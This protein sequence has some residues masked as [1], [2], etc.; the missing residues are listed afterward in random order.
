MIIFLV[1]RKSNV[2]KIFHIYNHMSLIFSL[3]TIHYRGYHI[4]PVLL[5]LA[6]LSFYTS[7]YSQK[8]AFY[9]QSN[10][11]YPKI[12][13]FTSGILQNKSDTT[14]SVNCIFHLTI[15]ENIIYRKEELGL[16]I[17]PG[18][19]HFSLDST[20][21]SHDFLTANGY[22]LPG[23][24]HVHLYF[25]TNGQDSIKIHRTIVVPPYEVVYEAISPQKYAVRCFP[26]DPSVQLYFITA[27]Q[28][29]LKH[30]LKPLSA[31]FITNGLIHK[32]QFVKDSNKMD[33][34]L[35]RSELFYRG[36]IIG[37]TTYQTWEKLTNTQIDTSEIV[38]QQKRPIVGLNSFVLLESGYT[39]ITYPNQL[40]QPFYTR[41]TL[42]PTVSV[43]GIPLTFNSMISTENNSFY[44]VNAFQFGIDGNQF[45]S[46]FS[47]NQ[48]TQQVATEQRLANHKQELQEVSAAIH[49][50]QLLSKPHL[51]V[52][53]DTNIVTDTLHQLKNNQIRQRRLLNQR[54]ASNKLIQLEQREAFLKDALQKDSLLLHRQKYQGIT[55][56]TLNRLIKNERYKGLIKGLLALNEFKVGLVTPHYS[57]H[58]LS[59]TPIYGL[60]TDM[61]FK[62]WC[63]KA[64][65]GN[66]LAFQPT[67]GLRSRQVP[68]FN[69]RTIA[70]QLGI[71]DRR[72]SLKVF[73][74]YYY[75]KNA[76]NNFAPNTSENHVISSGI[77]GYMI[78]DLTLKLEVAKSFFIADLNNKEYYTNNT[79][80]KTFDHNNGYMAYLFESNYKLNHNT[81]FEAKIRRL[82]AGYHSLGMPFLRTDLIEY[83]IKWQQYYWH[84]QIETALHYLLNRDNLLGN[85]SNTTVLKGYGAILRTHFRNKPNFLISYQPFNSQL[86][87]QERSVEWNAPAELITQQFY[88]LHVTLFYNKKI[89]AGQLQTN[90][91][92]QRS[93][94]QNSIGVV[95]KQETYQGNMSLSLVGGKQISYQLAT[96]ITELTS[97]SGQLHD[98][99][100]TLPLLKQKINFTLG[101]TGQYMQDQK[102]RQGA[103]AFTSYS[104]KKLVLSCRLSV[105]YLQ[106]DWGTLTN[107]NPEQQ[108]YFS[109]AHR[110]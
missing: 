108:V 37:K 76:P 101:L 109:I 45:K 90:T 107:G 99:A 75:F 82:D 95:Y 20:F 3:S 103:Y 65:I 64:T 42:N 102:T 24:Y 96:Y 67:F 17:K 71:I 104:L 62:R 52:P 87:I 19:T 36:V 110:F 80:N 7:I 85:K 81:F 32:Q 41:L 1:I 29:K 68:K 84:K 30:H 8:I 49:K 6:F 9:P 100:F 58:I 34:L 51:E 83:G 59:Q 86:I 35:F 54:E 15:N 28:G 60:H 77:E 12:T 50:Q 27:K 33:K 46:Y 43:L 39:N 55:N 61:E 21:S 72:N 53:L 2:G 48:F 91:S 93:V 97:S 66:R 44:P 94:N 98:I 38:V 73:G 11:V 74:G 10:A 25:L 89:R 16:M 5:L 56:D 4:K 13:D 18:I 14:T 47:Q 70:A 69:N 78:K 22:L 57:A 79:I 26:N 63:L 105:N 92:Y 40:S 106:G 31:S 88:V 23:N